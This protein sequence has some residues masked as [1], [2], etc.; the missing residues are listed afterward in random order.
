MINWSCFLR[1]KRLIVS[2]CF[3]MLD[4][5]IRKHS[6]SRI[7]APEK[8]FENYYLEQEVF[9]LRAERF[10]QDVASADVPK[11]KEW[12]RA[13]FLQGAQLA[14]KDVLDALSDFGTATAGLPEMRTSSAA[15]DL[16]ADGLRHYFSDVWADKL[17]GDTEPDTRP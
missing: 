9:G 4:S 5:N 14:S 11:M 7:F 10:A 6:M 13:A 15:Y 17:P 1:K 12:L 8:A 16:A 3:K 2:I